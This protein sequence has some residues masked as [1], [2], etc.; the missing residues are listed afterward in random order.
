[1][2]KYKMIYIEDKQ[3]RPKIHLSNIPTSW[4]RKNIELLKE[5]SF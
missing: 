1:M 4:I 2:I 3:V 5:G